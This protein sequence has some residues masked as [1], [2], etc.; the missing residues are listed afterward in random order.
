VNGQILKKEDIIKM[1][2]FIFRKIKNFLCRLPGIGKVIKAVMEFSNQ[3]RQIEI[4][5]G[6]VEQERKILKSLSSCI[7]GIGFQAASFEDLICYLYFDQKK[8][9]FYVDIGA[10]DGITFSNT[11]VFEQIG[12]EGICIEPDPVIFSMLDRNRKCIKYNVAIAKESDA[13]IR[14]ASISGWGGGGDGSPHYPASMLGVLESNM[15]PH[16]KHLV[17]ENRGKIEY[18]AVKI[19]TFSDIM[20]NHSEITYIDLLSLDV[21]GAE[22]DVLDTIDF[23]KYRFGL[24]CIENNYHGTVLYDYMSAKGYKVYMDI[25]HDVFFIPDEELKRKGE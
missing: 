9:G 2:K 5:Q 7:L 21:E 24:L 12:W 15:L 25:K 3:K 22:I 23:S 20:K 13:E 8:N 1:F 14:F 18:I 10:H 11:F 4:L 16:V 6:Y 19:K 17:Q